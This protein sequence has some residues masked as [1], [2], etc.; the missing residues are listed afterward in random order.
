LD[1]YPT[2]ELPNFY[3]ANI[4]GIAFKD[5]FFLTE[6]NILAIS[7]KAYSVL[8]KHNISNADTENL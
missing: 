3:W 2:R 4:H 1:L 6:K 7:D 8:A 5:D